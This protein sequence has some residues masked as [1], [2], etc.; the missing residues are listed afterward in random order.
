MPP[1]WK[2]AAVL[3]TAVEHCGGG[4]RV[5]GASAGVQTGA[6][7]G[8]RRAGRLG[9]RAR[10]QQAEAPESRMHLAHRVWRSYMES[11]VT[12]LFS[13]MWSSPH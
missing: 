10:V 5:P 8:A 13:S 1:L 2:E 11:D 3:T 4:L 6:V 9:R 7:S 12:K